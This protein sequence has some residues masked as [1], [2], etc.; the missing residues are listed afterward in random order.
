MNTQSQCSSMKGHLVMVATKELG[1]LSTDGRFV[2]AENSAHAIHRAE[3]EV[4]LKAVHEVVDAAR[5]GSR[6]SPTE[7]GTVGSEGAFSFPTSPNERLQP[8]R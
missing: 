2:V 3:P 5:T 1:D 6:L 8:T 4:V 7:A